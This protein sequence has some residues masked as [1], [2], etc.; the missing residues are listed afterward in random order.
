MPVQ[1]ALP[2][3]Q[4]VPRH[5]L[6]IS[7]PASVSEPAPAPAPTAPVR[8]RIWLFILRFG[9]IVDH[10][11]WGQDV[12]APPTPRAHGALEVLEP[13]HSSLHARVS[14]DAAAFEEVWKK[15]KQVCGRECGGG[16]KCKCNC[17]RKCDRKCDRECRGNRC[18]LVSRCCWHEVRGARGHNS[19][20][21][22]SESTADAGKVGG[23]WGVKAVVLCSRSQHQHQRQRQRSSA[24]P[25]VRG[26][27]MLGRRGIESR[28]AC[29]WCVERQPDGFTQVVHCNCKVHEW[30][31]GCVDDWQCCA[32]RAPASCRR[33]RLV[34]LAQRYAE[35]RRETQRR[36]E[37]TRALLAAGRH[38]RRRGLGTGR[39]GSPDVGTCMDL[40]GCTV[41]AVSLQSRLVYPKIQAASHSV[42]L[43]P[44][45]KGAMQSSTQSR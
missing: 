43:Y 15:G 45:A 31:E 5:D 33:P 29:A 11:R 36:K 39:R 10:G 4:A 22:A 23:R 40:C 8:R 32:A 30:G 12:G 7:V 35:R 17:R 1:V 2:E 6:V 13:R 41:V 44:T 26:E 28:A 24:G 16:C 34:R 42:H 21:G 25:G 27:R 9:R 37:E 19:R 38:G 18:W 14:P 3:D 20:E